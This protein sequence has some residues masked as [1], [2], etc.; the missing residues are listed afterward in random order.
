E[1][2]AL[3]M[4]LVGA[5]LQFDQDQLIAITGGDLRATMNG[6]PVPMWRPVFVRKGSVLQCQSAVKGCRVYV[7]F[8]G[9]INVP[10]VMGSKST[11]VRAGIGGFKGRPLKKEDTFVCGTWSEAGKL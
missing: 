11:Y 3:E 5:T 6:E 2:G 4:T 7:A 1:E 10:E 9:G 8:A